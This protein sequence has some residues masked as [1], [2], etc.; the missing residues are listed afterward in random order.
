MDRM[1]DRYGLWATFPYLDNVTI[2]SHDQQDHDANLV[3]FLHTATLLNL[4]YNKEKCVFSTNR[5]AILGYVVH[6]RAL[7]H[8]PDRM[9]PLM[10]LPLP[11]CPKDLKRCLG[12]FSYYAQWVPNYADKAHPLIQSTVFPL[13]AEAHQAFNR[14][15]ADNAKAVMHVVDETLPFQV[16]SDASDV[17][18]TA[19]LNQAGRP[20]AFFSRTLHAS[21][22]RHS[23][24]E[25]EA[26]AIVEAVRYWRH[27][28]ASR[29]FT[30]LT[31]QR[32][33][34]FM[35]NNTQRGKIKNDKILR[36]MIELSTYNYEILNRP[37]EL[38]EP[39]MPYPKVHVPAHRGTDS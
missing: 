21:E 39:L 13:R 22:I 29:R 12:F 26:Q 20:V 5:L 30:L 25:K 11:H 35:F 24:V 16:E 10:E 18:L 1:V 2:C 31:D 36:W 32:S 17:A 15:K 23:S 14:I 33:V 37:G 19:T 8:D 6:D 4:T 38:N 9:R 7:G 3:K 34:T 28:L 27:Y